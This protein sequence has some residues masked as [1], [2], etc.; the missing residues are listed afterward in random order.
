[1]SPATSRRK[2]FAS[3][4]GQDAD[5]VVKLIDVYPEKYPPTQAGRLPV[6]GRERRLPRAV[7]QEVR[8]AG[9]VVPNEVTQYTH[10]PAHA[11]HRFR[12]GHRIMVQVQSTWFP[13]I[14]RNP[15]TWVPNIFEAKESDFKAQ[16]HRIWRTPAQP[17]RVEIET[18]PG[19]RRATCMREPDSWECC[20]D[21]L[22]G[23][24]L[25]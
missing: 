22:T 6:H 8:E 17:S 4:T 13:L 12:K 7:P 21:R 25:W 19:R 10:R 9:A 5:W 3:T 23:I 18:V 1:M 14:D 16:T 11:D 20:C 15:Q 2:L 24:W